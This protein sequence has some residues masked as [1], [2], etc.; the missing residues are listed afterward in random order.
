[1]RLAHIGAKENERNIHR[2]IEA[3]GNNAG[4]TPE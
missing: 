4:S 1:M 3:V 2:D